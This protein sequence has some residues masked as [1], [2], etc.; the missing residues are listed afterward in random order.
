MAADK[1]GH[2]TLSVGT[3]GFPVSVSAAAWSEVALS[4]HSTAF[5][6]GKDMVG[7]PPS[8]GGMPCV[9]DERGEPVPLFHVFAVMEENTDFVA[10]CESL[11]GLS[12]A[13][14]QAASDFMYS[15]LQKNFVG[16]DIE[17]LVEAYGHGPAL[18]REIRC[19]V[20]W[21]TISRP[22][23]RGGL[24]MDLTEPC[25]ASS[26]ILS[27]TGQTAEEAALARTTGP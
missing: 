18:F 15:S 4:V 1:R 21:S 17:P 3:G 20:T 26:Y 2:E 5:E 19:R 12:A 9:P 24:R 7:L 13:A 27:D 25:E 14:I 11:P 10:V 23:G 16:L 6:S 22:W 8:M